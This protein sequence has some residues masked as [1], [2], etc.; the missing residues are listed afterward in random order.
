[1]KAVSTCAA[2]LSSFFLLSVNAQQFKTGAKALN[3]PFDCMLPD[4]SYKG[5][6]DANV[7]KE[8]HGSL[9][10]AK[11][12]CLASKQCTVL[13][14]FDAD[15]GSWRVC[16]AVKYDTKGKAYTYTR[17]KPGEGGQCVGL[18]INVR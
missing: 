7:N 3:Q 1:M 13:H 17:L 11:K 8:W 5:L 16:R 6:A 18:K 4:G 2:V 15:N 9:D 10:D 12:K 14:D